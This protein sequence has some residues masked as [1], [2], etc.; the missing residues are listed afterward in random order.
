MKFIKRQNN[1]FKI[2]MKK[3]WLLS[4]DHDGMFTDLSKNDLDNNNLRGKVK[5]LILSSESLEKNIS[6]LM[7]NCLKLKN[8]MN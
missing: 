1:Q 5:T 7:M 8:T 6:F 4:P 3:R 2:G